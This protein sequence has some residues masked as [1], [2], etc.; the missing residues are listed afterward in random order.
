M[1]ILGR[2][3]AFRS[4]I[5]LHL[6]ESARTNHKRKNNKPGHLLLY[7]DKSA[8][9]NLPAALRPHTYHVI[10][11]GEGRAGQNAQF[12]GTGQ[13]ADSVHLVE[14]LCSFYPL[15][16]H[17]HTRERAGMRDRGGSAVGARYIVRGGTT[18]HNC[19]VLNKNIEGAQGLCPWSPSQEGARDQSSSARRGLPSKGEARALHHQ[20]APASTLTMPCLLLS[21]RSTRWRKASTLSENHS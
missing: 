16:H 12:A 13:R 6:R 15:E 1:R 7:I 5:D 9:K 10:W 8:A 19:T 2:R 4:T 21:L 3:A 17:R 20:P 14:K 11:G 18:R